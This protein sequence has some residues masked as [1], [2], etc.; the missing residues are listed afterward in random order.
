MF[1]IPKISISARHFLGLDLAWKQSFIHNHPS[2][3]KEHLR[4]SSTKR[5]S[6][7]FDLLFKS[8]RQQCLMSILYTLILALKNVF[9]KYCPS[10]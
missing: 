3:A 7:V 4:G 10:L 6:V 8:M 1:V 2:E 9:R 5:E